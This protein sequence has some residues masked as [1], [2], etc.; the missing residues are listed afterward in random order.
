V[1]PECYRAAVE[2]AAAHVTHDV[3]VL[4]DDAHVLVEGCDGDVVLTLAVNP[5]SLRIE[6]AAFAGAADRIEAGM[7]EALCRVIE[8]LPL[9]E[10]ADHGALRLEHAL[11]E[12]P[13]PV[14]GIVTPRAV[15]SAFDRP[16]ALL[17]DALASWRTQMGAVEPTSTFDAGPTP[18]WRAMDDATRKG[19]ITAVIFGFTRAHELPDDLFAVVA[20]E[21]DVRLVLHAAPH[22]KLA[23][24]VMALE[25]SIRDAIDPRLEVYLE[26][27]RDK[28][29]LRR[30]AIVE[31]DR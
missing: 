27:I 25:R 17:R 16:H 3:P 19:A 31:N 11:R 12:G 23:P 14:G 26:E 6:Q 13:K 9:I 24:L 7:L 29:K 15:G 8:G 5:T 1:L 10:A 20:I 4:D 2:H 28:N 18:T 30:L 22:A 21:F